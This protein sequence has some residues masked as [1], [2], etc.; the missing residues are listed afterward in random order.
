MAKYLKHRET[1]AFIILIIHLNYNGFE[2]DKKKKRNLRNVL[3]LP[4]GGNERDQFACSSCLMVFVTMFRIIYSL[5]LFAVAA[6]TT[7]MT[8]CGAYALK[9]LVIYEKSAKEKR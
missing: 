6:L 8:A 3:S 4:V 9:K 2:C 5:I 1:Y 7:S